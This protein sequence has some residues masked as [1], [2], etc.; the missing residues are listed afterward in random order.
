M[1]CGS[2]PSSRLVLWA[3]AGVAAVAVLRSASLRWGAQDAE[4]D[5][6]LPGDD[7]LPGA[8]LVA[9]RAITIRALPQDVW[10]W[11]AQLGQGRG[12]FYSYDALEN[13]VGLDI[14]S[15]ERVEPQWQDLAP[16]DQVHL[17]PPVGL[18]VVTADPGRALVLRGA[19][20]VGGAPA[21][22]DFVWAFVLL[23][24]PEEGTTR[25]VVRERYGYLTRWARPMVE[26]V[27]W[28]SFLMSE[29]MLR[30]V[31]DRAEAAARAAG[32]ATGPGAERAGA[33]AARGE[34][35]R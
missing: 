12:G 18:D 25:L 22:Y 24:G 27:E 20:P 5:A 14:H 11:L 29:R 35:A 1:T 26:A 3:A 19:V 6:V 9:T 33:G 31:R 13:L 8:D 2:R 15:A 21:P 4:V 30:G 32:D 34:D 28:V 23:S 7:L 16:G 10:P 17:A